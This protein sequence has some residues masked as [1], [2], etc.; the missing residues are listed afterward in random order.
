MAFVQF[1]S[2]FDTLQDRRSYLQQHPELLTEQAVDAA[3]AYILDW[4]EKGYVKSS[5]IH[6]RLF[7]NLLKRAMEV[8]VE[9]AFLEAEPSREV[10]TAVSALLAEPS[11]IRLCANRHFL[12]SIQ[13]VGAFNFLRAKFED[14]PDKLRYVE[15]CWD[16]INMIMDKSPPQGA[17]PA[18][19]DEFE[20]VHQIVA[21]IT[22]KLLALATATPQQIVGLRRALY[23]LERLPE[24]TPGVDVHYSLSER[25][26]SGSGAYSVQF[27]E[28]AISEKSF[29][30]QSGSAGAS[31][32]EASENSVHTIY[33]E[34]PEGQQFKLDL[35]E[36]QWVE[37]FQWAEDVEQLLRQMPS[38]GL[39][40]DVRDDSRPD[41]VPPSTR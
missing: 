33:E 3:N 32:G 8:G 4:R 24:I 22:R 36:D 1:A 30:V 20:G 31:P 16:S 18:K 21:R 37:L 10:T 11:F 26:D 6:M 23:A 35:S 19:Q 39:R 15:A 25:C 38:E 13:A 41:C 40:L 27:C 29:V 5:L 7:R 9:P 34:Y 28:I 14:D 17:T 2:G 12:T